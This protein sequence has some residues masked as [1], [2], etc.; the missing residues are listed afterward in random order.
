MSDQEKPVGRMQVAT[1]RPDDSG[2]GIARLPR[3]LMAQLDLV[4]G[5][6]I[7]LV[8]KRATPARAVQPYPEDEGLEIIRLDGLQ[9]T[10]AGIGSGDFVDIRKVGS[11][12]AKRVVF[13]PVQKNLRLHGSSIALKR[14]FGMRPL[15]AGDVVATTGQQQTPQGDIPLELRAMLTGPAYV[16]QEIRLLVVETAPGGI[17]HVVADTEIELRPELEEPQPRSRR[18]VVGGAAAPRRTGISE[19]FVSYAWGGDASRQDQLREEI[20]DRL[21]AAAVSQGVRVIRD[22]E[23]IGTGNSISAFMRRLGAGKRIFVILSEKYLKSPHCMFE[24]NEIW[25]NAK[26]EK[27]QFLK[28]LRIYV[29]PDANIFTPGD[30]VNWS[31]YWKQEFE[32]LDELGRKHGVATLGEYGFQR[33]TQMQQ[34]HTNVPNLL[35]M[36]ADTVI[37]RNFEELERYGFANEPA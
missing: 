36:I 3:A 14:T 24:L 11:I 2:R 4:E 27:K 31:I 25:R 5:D 34:F 1:M 7:E 28:K 18:A 20:V 15:V 9:R 16:L 12:P 26:Q 35:G 22:K 13:A 6:V 30:W 21:C 33:L 8:G 10:N 29:L 17:V 37:P 32:A 19:I 23:V